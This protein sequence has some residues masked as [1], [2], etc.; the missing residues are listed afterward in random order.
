LLALAPADALAGASAYLRAFGLV[1]GA[2]LMAEAVAKANSAA[3]LGQTLRASLRFHAERLLP[4]V[5]ALAA[6]VEHGAEALTA[7]EAAL[8]P[9]Q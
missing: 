2:G 8:E 6:V 9:R 5:D 4:E 7:S 1:G 3:P